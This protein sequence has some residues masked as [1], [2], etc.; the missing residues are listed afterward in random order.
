[1]GGG[2]SIY[3]SSTA[4]ALIPPAANFCQRCLQNGHQCPAQADTDLCIFCEDHVACPLMKFERTPRPTS[5]TPVLRDQ[6]LLSEGQLEKQRSK[7]VVTV[8]ATDPVKFTRNGGQELF[9]AAIKEVATMLNQTEKLCSVE[10]CGKRLRRRNTT[11]RCVK[12]YYVP[13]LQRKT[14]KRAPV[15]HQNGNGVPTLVLTEHQVDRMFLALP[16]ED[17]VKCVQSWL[18]SEV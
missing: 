1:M 9:L 13:K 3:G 5:A 11:G 17:K 8:H 12:H 2:K 4:G 18:D 10:G 7:P 6:S 16:V 15:V 14:A